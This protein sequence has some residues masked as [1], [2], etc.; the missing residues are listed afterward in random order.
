MVYRLLALDIDGTLLNSNNRLD[1]QTKDAIQYAQKK[2][3]IVTLVS[4]RHFHSAAKVA[5]ALRLTQPIITHN[6]A[7]VSSSMDDPVYT[8]KIDHSVLIQLAEFLETY[9]CQIQMSHERLSVS[10]RPHSKNLIAKM[11]IGM[12]EPLFYPVTYVDS[13]SQYLLENYEAATDVKVKVDDKKTTDDLEKA[14]SDYFPSLETSRAGSDRMTIVRQGTS[15]FNGLLF[16]AGQLGIPLHE[17]VAVGDGFDDLEMIEKCGLG[18][19]MR[20]APKEVKAKAEWVT[21]SNDM[22]G[23]AYMV[24]EVFRKQIRVH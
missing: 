14:I 15:K 5:R 9:P 20:N 17:I 19:A 11:T 18:V 7:F 21:R 24:R 10:N 6:G 23:V 1:R 8:S 13:L 12:N 3:V 4:E 16:F 22:D 2:G